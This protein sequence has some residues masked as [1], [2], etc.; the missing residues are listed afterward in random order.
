MA[1]SDRRAPIVND[2]GPPP[3][4]SAMAQPW[5]LCVSP[6]HQDTVDVYLA[7]GSWRVL[8][9]DVTLAA[10]ILCWMSIRESRIGYSHFDFHEFSI[11]LALAAIAGSNFFCVRRSS[12]QY[13]FLLDRRRFFN[14][15]NA[16]LR[17][18]TYLYRP[19]FPLRVV[20][21]WP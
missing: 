12:H 19:N 8:V 2:G 14:T 13:R 1:L 5:P 4:I 9:K 11:P 20:N 17:P 21:G 7:S 3:Q 18:L 16:T 6:K 15:W 10:H